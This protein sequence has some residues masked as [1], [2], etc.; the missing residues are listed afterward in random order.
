MGTYIFYIPEIFP[1]LTL[2]MMI[3]HWEFGSSLAQTNAI[4]M[5]LTKG[6]IIDHWSP[7]GGCR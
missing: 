3:V 1:L 4:T 5:A 7:P 6:N 2:E